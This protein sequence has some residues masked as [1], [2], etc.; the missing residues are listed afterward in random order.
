[1]FDSFQGL[2]IILSIRN[3]V[4]VTRQALADM[5]QASEL[6]AIFVILSRPDF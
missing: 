2:N 1:V 3:I 4:L 6:M 5:V